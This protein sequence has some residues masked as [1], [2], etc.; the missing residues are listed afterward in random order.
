[1]GHNT[2]IL[3]SKY[4][5]IPTMSAEKAGKLIVLTGPTASGKSH[6]SSVLERDHGITVAVSATTRKL[7][8]GERWG[9][10]YYFLTR[11]RFEREINEGR[12][13]EW[14]EYAGNLYGTR[15]SEIEPVLQGNHVVTTTEIE[16]ASNFRNNIIKAYDDDWETRDALLESLTTVFL[17]VENGFVIKDR[18]FKRAGEGSFN[19]IDMRDNFRRRARRDWQDWKEHGHT[20][21][22]VVVNNGPIEL[23]VGQVLNI[24]HG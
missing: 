7:R 5:T 3:A 19:N 10:D 18:F 1:M 2:L 16:G 12:Y 8:R 21:D 24:L 13:L 15:K 6:I 22:H 14:N 23:A 9:K 4:D 17:G 11:T 20:F